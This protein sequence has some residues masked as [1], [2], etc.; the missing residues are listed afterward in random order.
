MTEPGSRAPLRPTSLLAGFYFPAMSFMVA[1]AAVAVVNWLGGF[2]WAGWMTLHLALLGGVSQLVLGS[3][4]FFTSAFL[5]TDPP[6]RG[7]VF[8]QVAVWNAGTL[9][10]V[11]SM[12]FGNPSL[13][14]AGG[15]LIV[16]GLLLF[17][18]SL[19]TMK[20]R[21]LQ[22]FSWAVRWYGSSAAFLSMGALAGIGM[23]G[24]AVWTGGSLLGAHIALNLTGWFGTAIVGTLHTFF[25]SLTGTRLGF[26]RLE[27]YTFVAWLTGVLALA[28]GLGSGNATLAVLGWISLG[29]AAVLLS[30]NMASS[31]RASS[32]PLPLAAT[33]VGTGQLFLC[34]GLA[35]GLAWS[36]ARGV[37]APFAAPGR[38]TLSILIILGWI[39]MT[40]AG[41]LLHLLTILARVRSR[42]TLP[43]PVPKPMQENLL[44][45]MAGIGI[46]GMAVAGTAGAEFP[47]VLAR[48][49]TIAAAIL[50]ARR[51]LALAARAA[52]SGSFRSGARGS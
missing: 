10:I 19:W 27:G 22:S 25:P 20:R 43:M 26:P 39:G 36:L 6:P 24:G 3:A 38:E 16:V 8:S 52:F 21:S 11:V 37:W 31:L 14:E 45:A 42:F 35:V 48:A 50:L 44:V 12:P 47:E 2:A 28:G 29:T 51:L 4:Q 18:S 17:A 15:V 49:V 9:M 41:S 34:A 32:G 1:A 7:L 13:A 23:A 30:I 33:L 46:A 40:V 5:A